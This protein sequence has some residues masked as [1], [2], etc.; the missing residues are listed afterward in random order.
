MFAT[1]GGHHAGIGNEG[2]DN[3]GRDDVVEKPL[4]DSLRHVDLRKLDIDREYVDTMV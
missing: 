4:V 2:Q 1:C 3:G